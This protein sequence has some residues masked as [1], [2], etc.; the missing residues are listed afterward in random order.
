M[1]D[2]RHLSDRFGRFPRRQGRGIL[3]WAD[4]LD[5]FE[6]VD[7]L[8]ADIERREL[9]VNVFLIAPVPDLRAKLASLYPDCHVLSPPLP[10]GTI[11]RRYL[12]RSKAYLMILLGGA[13]VPA[14]LV[15]QAGKLGAV[16]AAREIA[17]EP[18]GAHAWLRDRTLLS[19]IDRFFVASP[20]AER[21][22]REAGVPAAL[23]S[24]LAPSGTDPGAPTHRLF[25]AIEPL[26]TRKNRL[27]DRH[28]FRN[29]M[30]RW[31]VN[32][33]ET[34]ALRPVKALKYQRIDTL[35]ALRRVLGP[36]EVILCLGNGPSSEDPRLRDLAYD[37]LFRVNHMWLERGILTDP[38]VVFTGVVDTFRRVTGRA[39]FV[40]PDADNETRM[41]QKT[42]LTRRRFR[43]ATAEQL[44]TVEF[45]RFGSF[46]P[47]NGAV[48]L[49]TAAALR[50]K[51]L[52]IAGIDLF[53]HPAGSYPGNSRIA[54]AYALGHDRDTELSFILR[55]LDRF[56]GE[57]EIFSEVLAH[58][59]Q[60]HLARKSDY[61]TG[62]PI[63]ASAL[64]ST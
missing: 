9:R 34:A 20:G 32:L 37:L 47:S 44:G 5:R 28:G 14:Q 40:L 56:D 61:P 31:L 2:R 24:V 16:V 52:I 62:L 26:I 33:M 1:F 6:A 60:L 63:V 45:A 12:L 41:L 3:V 4:R 59:W 50:P 15:V 18:D 13:P 46:L 22:L 58:Q 42:L 19:A 51:R 25:D 54:N 21:R 17:S 35:A 30:R 29:R 23:V 53:Q 48:M 7:E 11:R 43:Y 36:S 38:D 49:A 55:T 39:M 27:A 10:I 8:L 64:H 57:V